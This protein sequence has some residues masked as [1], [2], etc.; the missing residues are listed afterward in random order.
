MKRS[1]RR[2]IAAGYATKMVYAWSGL[3]GVAGMPVEG[4]FRATRAF[5]R[6]N[7][8]VQLKGTGLRVEARKLDDEGRYLPGS[9]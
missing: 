7:G 8:L 3:S 6:R 4:A 1:T 9:R 5:I 2:R